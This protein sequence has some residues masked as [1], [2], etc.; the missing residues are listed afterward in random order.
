MSLEQASAAAMA[1]T[2]PG[3][4]TSRYTSP[5][6]LSVTVTTC[7]NAGTGSMLWIGL[8]LGNS[9]WISITSQE[10]FFKAAST[11]IKLFGDS[12][13]LMLMAKLCCH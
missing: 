6:C 13:L 8:E 3:M 1:I 2:L 5:L 10:F 4:G 12:Q 11:G 9:N 7:V